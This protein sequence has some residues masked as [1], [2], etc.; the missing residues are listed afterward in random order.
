[1]AMLIAEQER[2][3]MTVREF[4]GSRGITPTTLYWWR[5]R[6]GARRRP[7]ALVPVEVVDHEVVVARR[8]PDDSAFEVEI[9]GSVTLRIRAGFDE[10]ELRRLMRALRC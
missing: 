8:S 6:L 4:A 5:S 2:S 3:G 9:D 7:A 1:M 10:A